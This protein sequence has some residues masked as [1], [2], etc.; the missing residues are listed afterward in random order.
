MNISLL[1]LSLVCMT[2]LSP[3]LFSGA[4]FFKDDAPLVASAPAGDPKGE[5]NVAS[6]SKLPRGSGLATRFPGDKGIEQDAAVVFAEQFEDSEWRSRFGEATPL[7]QNALAVVDQSSTS[8]LI[9]SGTLEVRADLK[10]NHGGGLTKWFE[11]SE[12]IFIRF[13]TRF[14]A[15]C[16]YVHHFCTLRANKSWTRGKEKWSGFGGAGVKPVGDERFST[17]IEPWGDWGRNTPPGKWNFYSYWHTMSAAPDGKYWGN[18]FRPKKQPLIERAKWICVEMM[19]VHNTPGKNDGE[20]AFWID[21]KLRGHWTDIN[22]RKSEK[23]LANAFTLT[24]YVTDRW[25]KNDINIVY[26]DN[27][28]IARKYVGPTAPPTKR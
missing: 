12:R 6:K 14:H 19:L 11:P 15:E 2:S 20:Q 18:A 13:Y 25:T 8:P 5:R 17:G 26:F 22:W 28:V 23:L 16:D 24:S 9:G 21:G 1:P 4:S 10:K 27:L 3:A 7:K